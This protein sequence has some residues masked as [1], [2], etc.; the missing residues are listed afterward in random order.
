MP[1]PGRLSRF[2]AVAIVVGVVV[3]FWWF[4]FR[5]NWQPRPIIEVSG[6]TESRTLE[7]TVA[8]EECG[9][10]DP[11]VEVGDRVD[12]VVLAAKFDEGDGDCDSIGMQTRVS[13]QLDRVLGDRRIEV[14]VSRDLDCDI[15][16]ADAI[17]CVT[18]AGP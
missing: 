1:R 11:R 18:S 13:V 3:A 12:A 2:V 9:R 10:G 17:P 15:R 16:G 5:S 4:G 6:S 8:H 14:R 7:V